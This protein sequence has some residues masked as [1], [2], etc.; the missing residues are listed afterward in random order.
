MVAQVPQGGSP[1]PLP[2][3]SDNAP[4]SPLPTSAPPQPAPAAP[5]PPHM[6]E[7]PT[8]APTPLPGPPGSGPAMSGPQP[9]GGTGPGPGRPPYTS[10]P[11]TPVGP[12][13]P[14]GRSGSGPR[15]RLLRGGLAVVAIVALVFAVISLGVGLVALSK[16]VDAQNTAQSAAGNADTGPVDVGGVP[17]ESPSTESAQQ[18]GTGTGSDTDLATDPAVNSSGSP[19][20]LG[21]PKITKET[22]YPLA[23]AP[24]SLTVHLVGCDASAVDL[25]VPSV[26]VGEDKQELRVGNE[27]GSNQVVALSI[28]QTVDAARAPAPTVGAFDCAEL[29]RTARLPNNSQVQAAKGVV[30]CIKTNYV[31]SAN[32]NETW[33][34]V[35]VEVTN[36]AA[37]G[38]VSLRVKAW[39]LPR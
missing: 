32:E 30:L 14:V 5:S 17:Q 36:I 11:T 29:I 25:D 7:P 39:N 23:Y 22:D 20:P 33:K 26:G 37:D 10:S 27:C 18:P 2:G 15:Q 31:Q 24:E 9:Y 16:A 34:M 6:P 38:A 1:P 12:V 4:T 28:P 8:A 13:Q 21:E 3:S 19:A 35:V